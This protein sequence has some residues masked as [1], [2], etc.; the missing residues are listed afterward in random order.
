MDLP[1]SEQGPMAGFSEYGNEL[2]GSI[3]LWDFFINRQAIFCWK[4]SLSTWRLLLLLLLLSSS[5][6][7]SLI[8]QFRDKTHIIIKNK[9]ALFKCTSP[10]S[11]TKVYC[12][13]LRWD[14]LVIM[15][16]VS[17]MLTQL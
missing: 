5:S 11:V 3:K 1:S 13:R 14:G 6:S 16:E 7:W 8:V 2:L 4:E 9:L 12:T 17:R 15:V 10:S